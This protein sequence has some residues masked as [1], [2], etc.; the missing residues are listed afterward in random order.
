[1][2][3]V[4]A[5]Y[6]QTGGVCEIRMLE[7]EVA[8]AAGARHAAKGKDGRCVPIDE[9]V[10][11]SRTSRG[12]FD[13]NSPIRHGGSKQLD[14]GVPREVLA[15]FDALSRLPEPEEPKS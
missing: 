7:E 12:G 5:L 15:I 10:A 2:T 1:M 8:D 4:A 9:A 13:G 14:A 3:L 6:V 11:W